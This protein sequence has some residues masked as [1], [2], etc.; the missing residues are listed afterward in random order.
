MNAASHV[1]FIALAYAAT[2]IVVG[3]LIVW[4]MLDHRALRRTLADFE[5]R[6]V[7]R[8][9]DERGKPS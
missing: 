1:T 6:G 9:S 8:R 4:I 7:A 2:V 5:Q 3:V